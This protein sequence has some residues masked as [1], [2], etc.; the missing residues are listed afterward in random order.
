MSR[1]DETYSQTSY[2]RNAGCHSHSDLDKVRH[3]DIINFA[4]EEEKKAT[5]FLQNQDTSHMEDAGDEG[6]GVGMHEGVDFLAVHDDD[7]V[8][9][10]GGE[11]QML[12][13]QDSDEEDEKR[14]AYLPLSDDKEVLQMTSSMNN[15][16]EERFMKTHAMRL[17][18]QKEKKK[19]EDEFRSGSITHSQAMALNKIPSAKYMP[20]HKTRVYNEW[21]E[22]QKELRKVK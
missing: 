7:S 11:P 10:N 16:D 20:T 13:F 17:L 21:L 1:F 5:Q 4:L 2:N 22:A 12:L 15:V 3:D 9:S 18:L 6:A 19:R 8:G 14:D